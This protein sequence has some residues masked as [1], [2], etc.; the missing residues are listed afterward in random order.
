MQ[1]EAVKENLREHYITPA[2]L[3]LMGKRARDWTEEFIRDQI[4]EFKRTIPEYPEVCEVLEGELYARSLNDLHQRVRRA[5][6]DELSRFLSSPALDPDK[7][8]IARTELEL[9]SLRR[10]NGRNTH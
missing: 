1:P 4:Q 5:S 3:E 2:Y 8:E 9:R 7:A 10:A 6:A